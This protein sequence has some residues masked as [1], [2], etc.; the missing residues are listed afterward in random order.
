MKTKIATSLF[1]LFSVIICM[2][3]QQTKPHIVGIWKLVSYKYGDMPSQLMPDSIQRV[4]II[5]RNS[6]TWIEYQK[7]NKN[8][9]A[10]GGGTYVLKGHSY[11][12]NL[13]FGLGMSTFL[14]KKQTFTLKFKK[15]SMIQSGE[16]SNNFKIEEVWRK[17]ES[18]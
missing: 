18:L 17:V 1:L 8:I 14:G 16:L 12:E 4:K 11:N 3:A 9:T 13:I 2:N 6:F 15:G 10:S 5:T 7:K